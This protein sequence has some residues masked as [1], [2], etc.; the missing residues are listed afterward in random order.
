MDL[1]AKNKEHLE[2]A[3]RFL[4]MSFTKV[5]QTAYPAM[6]GFYRML[7]SWWGL[8]ESLLAMEIGLKLGKSRGTA[9]CLDK[10]TP[11]RFVFVDALA[12]SDK[13]FLEDILKNNQELPL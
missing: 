3:A 5:G 7:E 1:E 13:V 9:G 6:P 10:L 11:C 8:Q 12:K 2:L 4:M